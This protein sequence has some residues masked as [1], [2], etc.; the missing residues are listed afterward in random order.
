MCLI[1]TK[2]SATSTSTTTNN[3]MIRLIKKSA[4]GIG[5]ECLILLFA[6]E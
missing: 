3:K 1:H 4:V 2:Q 6:H 5:N